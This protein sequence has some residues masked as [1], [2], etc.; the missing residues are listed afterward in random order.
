M[1]LQSAEDRM[2]RYPCYVCRQ[3]F[4]RDQL[5]HNRIWAGYQGRLKTGWVLMCAR[6]SAQ[7]DEHWRR[8]AEMQKVI[9]AAGLVIMVVIAV[10]F[11]AIR[12]Y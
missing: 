6:C 3:S 12:G 5:G 10:L 8:E 1:L 2:R 11:Y 4:P 7:V 9:A